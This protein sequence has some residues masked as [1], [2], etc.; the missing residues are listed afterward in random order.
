MT[1]EQNAKLAPMEL[2]EVKARELEEKFD[3]E[4][5]FR[6]LA[7]VAARIVGTLL[8]ILSLFHYYTAGFGLLPEMIHRG[9][10]LAFVLGLVFLVF[11]FSR[12][13]YDEPA[14][15][16][17]LR[18][19]GI[20]VIDWGLAIIAVV[21]V[22]HVPLIPLDDLAFRVGNPTSTDVVLGSLL[23]LILLEATRRSVGWPLPIISVLFM[24]YALY[25]P[26]MPGILVH[27]G[28]TVSQLVDHLYLTTQGIYGI[29]LGVVATYVFHFV[30]FGVFATRI[31]LGQL[32]LDCAAW[33]AGRF[34]GGPAKVSIFGSA[35]FG[36]ISGSSV[37]N[38]VTVGSLTIPAMIRLGYKRHFAA[39]VESASSTGGQITPP[40][41]G[42]A[43]FLMIEF[44]NLPYTTII[45]AAIVPAFMHFFGVLMQVHF[46]AKR[47]GLRGMT[48]EEMPDLKEALKRD[49]P[50]IIPL[51]VLIAV[52]LSGYTPYLAAFWG[53]TLCIAVG[54]LN[55]RKRMTIGEVF[56]GLR[57]GAKYALAVGAAA[58][59]VGII[60]GVVTLTGVGF[61]ISYIVTSTA[62]QLAIYFGTILPVSWFAPQTLTLLFTL[63]MTGMVC[64]L[65]GCGI[66]TT[67]NYIIMATIAAPAL[68]LLG[69][70]PI[71]AHFFVFYY[72][73]LADITP[74]VALA[75]YAAAGMAGAD[76]FKTGNTAFRLGLGKV[77]VPFVFVFS[78]SLLLVT[79]NFNWPDFFIAFFG[80]VIGIT[81]LGAA[82]SGFFLVR[83]KI[84]ENVLL[85]FAAM[86]LVAPEIYSS[87]VGLILLLPVV[88]RHLVASRR[89]AY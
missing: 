78:P 2:D 7:P 75:A 16:S 40:I 89:P 77:L 19:L 22:I 80:C 13:G 72:G 5:R 6:P 15:P 59:T 71:V 68:G 88:V 61:K 52:L 48:K 3:S 8:I 12:K 37:A 79:S 41:M 18:P 30:L 82:L 50:T 55:P 63:V 45:L 1:E 47:T 23:I 74:P 24:L 33:V 57:D 44:L 20:S 29:A 83:T 86:L 49:W 69:V 65:M 39:A 58:A 54:L 4:I 62:A 14:K 67:A 84:W 9:I 25:G 53:I 36:M 85:I 51:V 34:A 42:A 21:A 43:A 32:F 28:A 73:V 10:H 31:G 87:I 26:S 64:I 70:E 38:A 17:L 56:E 81:A 76:P 60:V 11:P 35:L 66:P 27:P 46:E